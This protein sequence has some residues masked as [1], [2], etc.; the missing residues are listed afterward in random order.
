VKP[1]TP[2][3]PPTGKNVQW[4]LI[5][6]LSLNYLSLVSNG[7]E[8][9]QQILAVHNF[10]GSASSRKMIDGITR[11]ASRNHFARLLSEHGVHFA[12]GTRV[13]IEFDE[14]QF[15]GSGV[16]LFASV[17]E[18]FL[19]HY[20]HL[21]SFSQMAATTKQRKEVLREWPPRAGRQILL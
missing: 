18:N 20:V 1:T 7:R 16:Y 3:R 19:G 17:L 14:E 4:R 15:V 13:E 6:Q 10:T 21:N 11:I 5:S 12:R 8:A 9:L 2:I